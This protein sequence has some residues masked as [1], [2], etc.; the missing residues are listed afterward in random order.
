MEE[1][2][3]FSGNLVLYQERRIY[4]YKRT[5]YPTVLSF[6]LSSS[7]N[8]LYFIPIQFCFQP[9]P[10]HIYYP[11]EVLCPDRVVQSSFQ[12]PMRHHV[13]IPFEQL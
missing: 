3:V 5:Y 13:S 6:F 11:L 7:H 1:R 4:V 8:I 2:E 9:L 12:S 10:L